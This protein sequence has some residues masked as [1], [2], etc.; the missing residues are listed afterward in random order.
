MKKY[1][2][3]ILALG[4]GSAKPASGGDT[5]T[6]NNYLSWCNVT[7][8]G[9]SGSSAPSQMLTETDGAKITVTAT[10]LATFVW[11]Y[12]QGTD[13]DAGGASHDQGTGTDHTT[14]ITMSGN[15]TID[16]CCPEPGQ[17]CTF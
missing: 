11:G 12:W 6:I 16:A 9:G 17:G 2:V 1:L 13:G 15:K 8:N 14:T 4:C 3:L 5:L 10:P 7:V